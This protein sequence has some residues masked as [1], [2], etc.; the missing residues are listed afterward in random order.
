MSIECQMAPGPQGRGTYHSELPFDTLNLVSG[1]V[2][3]HHP[4]WRYRFN[5]KWRAPVDGVANVFVCP[6]A[7]LILTLEPFQLVVK[8]RS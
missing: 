6:L 4:F 3:V 5:A 8:L 1:T 2:L 7:L